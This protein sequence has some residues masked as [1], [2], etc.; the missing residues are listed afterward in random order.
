MLVKDE[1]LSAVGAITGL[2]KVSGSIVET[3]AELQLSVCNIDIMHIGGYN[4]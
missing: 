4:Q 1:G 3:L 2:M